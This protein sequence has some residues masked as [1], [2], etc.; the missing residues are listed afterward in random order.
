MGNNIVDPIE[1][2]RTQIQQ[3]R[4]DSG[5]GKRRQKKIADAAKAAAKA[6]STVAGA[7]G[8]GV[9]SAIS[10]TVRGVANL[11]EFI[12]EQDKANTRQKGRFNSEERIAD[13]KSD[14]KRAAQ[15]YVEVPTQENKRAY[16]ETLKNFEAEIKTYESLGGKYTGEKF[17][18]LT[19]KEG[20][21]DGILKDTQIGAPKAQV[22]N[23]LAKQ[24]TLNK[25]KVMEDNQG[26]VE[27][28]KSEAGVQ[29][30]S[31]TAAIIASIRASGLNPTIDAI[32]AAQAV[33]GGDG[34]GGGG[35]SKSYKVYSEQET[36]NLAN[37]I[38]QNLL[39]RT[40]TAE[41]LARATQNL[42]VESKANP[43]VTTSTGGA[44][45]TSGGIDSQEILKQEFKLAPE[46]ETYQKA[47]TYFDAMIGALRGP[48]GG[49]V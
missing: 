36:S 6:T 24:G 16:N 44:T 7:I 18:P 8:G 42:N 23:Q 25:L 33:L 49:G 1:A 12:L 17:A 20:V 39:G 10:G 4:W 13:Y 28:A 26:K 27:F 21:P 37:T 11:P 45:V 46:Y 5:A 29:L 31:D 40:A 32:A 9:E 48:A 19:A 3:D 30:S 14:L 15:R 43:T 34:G 2:G 22:P 38:A 41:E 35:T 47:T